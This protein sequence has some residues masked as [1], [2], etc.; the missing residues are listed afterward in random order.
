MIESLLVVLSRPHPGKDD[1]FNDWY[2][3]IHFRDVL[4]FRGSIAAQR[5]HLSDKQIAVYRNPLK[6]KY[7]ALYEVS[8]ADRFTREHME[9]IGS[10]RMQI[11]LAFDN[12]AVYDYYFFPCQFIDNA[13]GE[14][15]D[16]S[17]VMQ[18]ITAKPGQE[19]A[20]RRWY[21]QEH[22]M[23]A[24]SR[25][26]VRSGALLEYRK[27]GQ[28]FPEDPE[29]NFLAIYRLSDRRAM[30]NWTGPAALAASTL[31]DAKLLETSCWDVH[32]PRLTKDSVLNPTSELLAAE[33]K[34]RA[35]MGDKIIQLS[36]P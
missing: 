6:W 29:S 11:A 2:S 28:M 12:S 9:A 23:P 36:R 19:A 5:F 22:L 32:I 24:V 35:R 13:P 1:E 15:V 34:A 27:T 8:D 30:D 17:V 18:Q 10:L 7:L 26:G 16:G 3:N 14:P 33:E 31:I 25:P 4:R 21:G 20:F